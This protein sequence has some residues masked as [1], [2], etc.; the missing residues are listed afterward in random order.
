MLGIPTIKVKHKFTSKA[1]RCPDFEAKKMYRY[2]YMVSPN[3][4]TLFISFQCV[5]SRQDRKTPLLNVEQPYEGNVCF[6]EFKFN[7]FALH[8]N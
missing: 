2:I 5:Q 6:W 1:K 7:L 4:V 3:V 8:E